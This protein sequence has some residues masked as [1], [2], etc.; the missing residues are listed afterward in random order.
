MWDGR[1][2]GWVLPLRDGPGSRLCSRTPSLP[3]RDWCGPCLPRTHNS[4]IGRWAGGGG[5]R[6]WLAS[7]VSP[8][9][10][11]LRPPPSLPASADLKVASLVLAA[12]AFSQFQSISRPPHTVSGPQDKRLGSWAAAPHREGGPGGVTS[13]VAGESGEMTW[14]DACPARTCARARDGHCSALVDFTCGSGVRMVMCV[15]ERRSGCHFP[16]AGPRGRRLCSQ[17][18]ITS[19]ILTARMAI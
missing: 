15:L 3:F 14:E 7:P 2:L 5:W 4:G 16:L 19:I 1:F 9:L 17:S 13:K 18:Q 10:S 11:S 6:G 12:L 8:H